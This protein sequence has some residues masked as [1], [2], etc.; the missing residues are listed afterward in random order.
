MER[1]AVR[2]KNALPDNFPLLSVVVAQDHWD[3]AE[4]TGWLIDTQPGRRYALDMESAR[5][6]QHERAAGQ[7][8]WQDQ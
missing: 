4:M 1:Q 7:I 8:G 5:V 3:D 2:C 6:L